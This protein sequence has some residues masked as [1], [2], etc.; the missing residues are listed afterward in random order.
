MKHRDF[1]CLAAV[2]SLILIFCCGCGEAG[3]G[4]SAS[5]KTA[6]I[7]QAG[8]T[9]VLTPEAGGSEQA[10][11]DPL[12]L[13]FSHSD[14]GYFMGKLTAEGKKVN[15][16]VTGPDDIIYQYF[17]ETPNEWTA[18]PLT[19]GDG[20][21]LVLA[22]EDVGDGQYASLFSYPLDVEL[23]DEFFPFLYPNQYVS[24]TAD[25]EATA[26]AASLSEGQETDLDALREIY[27]Y[28]I[29]NITY[30]DEK[31]AAVESGY[32]PDIDE[33]LRTG[34]GIC[35]DY[36]A[37]TCAMLRS[38][39]IP[40]RL[41]IG[42]TGDIRHAWIDVYIQAVGWVERAVEFNGNEWKFMDPTFASAAGD[43]QTVSEYI[44]DGENY[45]LQY[46]R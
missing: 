31:A 41:A 43:S 40:C 4:G 30:D 32:L 39:S 37:L 38:L 5:S 35:F 3:K 29:S 42:Y 36:A 28:I 7:Y 12:I 27:E 8:Q 34:T 23:S 13:D 21:Y 22:F 45:V 14:Q 46:I 15:I 11:G 33:T 20:P 16:Q 19:A 1:R 18:F 25:S 9:V 10:G 44:G 17:L 24:F 6:S 2:L 26:L